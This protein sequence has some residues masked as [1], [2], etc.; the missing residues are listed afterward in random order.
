[1]WTA[2]GVE[3]IVGRFDTLAA[4]DFGAEVAET[5]VDRISQANQALELVC[6]VENLLVS[7]DDQLWLFSHFRK[8]NEMV[9]KNWRR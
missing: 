9:L 6:H 3:L 2:T 5:C 4:E 1:M 8:V 7:Q